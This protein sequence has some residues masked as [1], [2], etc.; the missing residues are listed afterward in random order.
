MA[1]TEPAPRR[2]P[3]APSCLVLRRPRA[4]AGPLSTASPENLAPSGAEDAER[5]S[6]PGECEIRKET[7][8][9]SLLVLTFP[10]PFRSLWL[11]PYSESAPGAPRWER[12]S[13]ITRSLSASR[14]SPYAPCNLKGCLSATRSAGAPERGK[15]AR[16]CQESLGSEK[17]QRFRNE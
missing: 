5:A 6:A 16:A 7:V 2:E 1:S 15:K 12:K 10:R 9:S 3:R 14:A 8:N 4:P 11:T 17:V 13:E